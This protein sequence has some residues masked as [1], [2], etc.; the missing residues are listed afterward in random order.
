MSGVAKSPRVLAPVALLELGNDYAAAAEFL[1]DNHPSTVIPFIPIPYYLLGH[2][3]ELELKAYLSA[4]GAGEKELRDL[5]HDLLRVL[6][7]AR[8]L[9]LDA[10]VTLLAEEEKSLR[11]ISAFYDEKELEYSFVT[12]GEGYLVSYPDPK[13]L[14]SLAARLYSALREHCGR[15]TRE[16]RATSSDPAR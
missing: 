3:I 1:F 7:R 15:R 10:L 4:E 8:S 14:R 5:G 13:F 12:A 9:G 16:Q 2:A 6:A 11:M